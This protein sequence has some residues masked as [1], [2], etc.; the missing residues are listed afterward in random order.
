[1]TNSE[2]KGTNKEAE[3]R[4]MR[5]RTVEEVNMMMNVKVFSLFDTISFSQSKLFSKDNC[6]VK[7]TLESIQLTPERNTYFFIDSSKPGFYES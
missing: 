1:M 6:H 3:S 4:I 5:K 2:W 7:F